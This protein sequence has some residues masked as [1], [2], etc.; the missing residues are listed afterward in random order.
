MYIVGSHVF[1]IIFQQ[2]LINC[3]LEILVSPEKDL[4]N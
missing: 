1:F 4:T 3:F 2:Q